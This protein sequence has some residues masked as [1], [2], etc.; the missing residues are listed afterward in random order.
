MIGTPESPRPAAE[1]P[2][3]GDST[4]FEDDF[5]TPRTAPVAA[6]SAGVVKQVR[7]DEVRRL[8]LAEALQPL[9]PLVTDTLAAASSGAEEDTSASSRHL[10]QTRLTKR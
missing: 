2:T 5:C 4:D 1:I 9:Q 8:N 3:G 6:D 7:F 10:V